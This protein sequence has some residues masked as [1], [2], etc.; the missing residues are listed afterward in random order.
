MQIA[1]KWGDGKV[2]LTGVVDVELVDDALVAAAE[3]DHEVLDGDGPVPVARPRRRPRRV[4]HLLPL[5]D[6]RRRQ[7]GGG[8]RAVVLPEIEALF[9]L[10]LNTRSAQCPV[11]LFCFFLLLSCSNPVFSCALF[12]PNAA[13]TAYST[14]KTASLSRSPDRQHSARC[15]GMGRWV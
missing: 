7:H 8:R 10:F 3:D 5:E 11:S 14:A 12:E 2:V 13:A 1:K 6:G 9:S 4:P 15:G